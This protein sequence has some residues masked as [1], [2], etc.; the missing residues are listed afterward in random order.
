VG[1]SIQWT[2]ISSIA[3]P[4]GWL[5][6]SS[7]VGVGRSRPIDGEDAREVSRCSP[8]DVNM[9]GFVSGDDAD[10]FSTMYEAGDP[11]ADIDH[12]GFVNG[13]DMEAFTTTFSLGCTG[14]VP[15]CGRADV[16][17]DGFINGDDADLFYEAYK[18]GDPAADLDV[19]GFVNG[20]DLELFARAFEGGC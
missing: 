18:L 16:N 5:R 17:V 14:P 8:A 10:L 11:G 15:P 1:D 20:D 7:L 6:W 13:E 4:S 12:N 2:G 19:N 3:M 9:D